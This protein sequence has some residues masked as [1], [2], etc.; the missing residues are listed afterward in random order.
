MLKLIPHIR[1]QREKKMYTFLLSIQLDI[2][3]VI[4]IIQNCTKYADTC[5]CCH[6]VLQKILQ[7]RD[8]H[9]A[10]QKS[11]SC[12]CEVQVVKSYITMMK[13]KLSQIRTQFGFNRK[14][15]C[16]SSF[17]GIRKN[18]LCTFVFSYRAWLKVF[19]CVEQRIS[20]YLLH[21]I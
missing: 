3:F 11:W 1:S 9:V 20:N 16:W 13:S 19:P 8:G 12:C 17:F 15:T 5:L 14:P 21:E 4:R 6:A 10:K 18:F 2:L 7:T